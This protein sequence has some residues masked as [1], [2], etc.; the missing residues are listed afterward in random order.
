MHQEIVLGE[1]GQVFEIEMAELPREP[2]AVTVTN[3][4]DEP[5]AATTACDVDPVA[6]TLVEDARR[7]ARE[8]YVASTAGIADNTRYRLGSER[9]TVYRVAGSQRLILRRPLLE[10]TA[11]GV[12]LRG[13]RIVAR[14]DHAWASDVAKLTEHLEIEGY[15]LAWSTGERT[16]ADLVR[17][18]LGA[19]VVPDDIDGRYPGWRQRVRDPRH[20]IAEAAAIVRVD[21]ARYPSIRRARDAAAVR[22]LVIAR[23]QLVA[24]EEAVMFRGD[25][26]PELV[27]AEHRYQARLHELARSPA[28]RP[29]AEAPAE[30]VPAPASELVSVGILDGVMATFA[31]KPVVSRAALVGFVSA[32][33]PRVLLASRTDREMVAMFLAAQTVAR[34]ARALRYEIVLRLRQPHEEA[35][36]S[37]V[38]AD[39]PAMAW[40]DRWLAGRTKLAFHE[41]STLAQ[42]WAPKLTDAEC[43]EVARRLA[44]HRSMTMDKLT[45]FYFERVIRELQARARVPA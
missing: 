41:L 25:P 1:S 13:C 26:Y 34:N 9:I 27:A 14:I 7:G 43:G 38:A 16:T 30:A 39:L 3:W 23:A 5:Q 32:W 2:V 4:R 40:F 10:A 29:P 37:V 15:Q 11:E 17:L 18:P 28:P 12:A 35:R 24:V 6:T 42:H 33:L 21:L 31:D 44:G 22:E 19:R 45:R 8:I 36:A 20:A